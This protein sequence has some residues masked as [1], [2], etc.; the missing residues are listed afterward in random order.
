MKEVNWIRVSETWSTRDTA[1]GKLEYS[2]YIHP[3]IDYSY[4][5]YMRSKQVIWWEYRRGNNRQLSLWFLNL[6]ESFCRHVETVKLLVYWHDVYEYKTE[7]WD[8]E[9]IVD[10]IEIDPTWEKKDLISELN[11]CRFNWDWMKLEVLLWR[12]LT[13]DYIKE[14]YKFSDYKLLNASNHNLPN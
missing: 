11:G 5:M 12:D 14:K 8:T 9:L 7:E 13:T 10:P 4:A 2:W 6:F 1:K 3:L